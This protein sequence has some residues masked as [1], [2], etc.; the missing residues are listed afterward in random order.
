MVWTVGRGYVNDFAG[1]VSYSESSAI[2][3]VISSRHFFWLVTRSF[4]DIHSFFLFWKSRLPLDVSDDQTEGCPRHLD[5]ENRVM[6]R[7]VF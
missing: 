4:R 3:Q 7:E 6:I 1:Q 5:E 2:S